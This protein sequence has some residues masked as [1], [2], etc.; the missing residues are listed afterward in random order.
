MSKELIVGIVDAAV[1]LIG[2]LVGRFA[3]PELAEEIAWVIAALQPVVVA[4]LVR[5]FEED[6]AERVAAKLR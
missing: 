3:A 1:I 6:V 2:F 5:Y 4:I